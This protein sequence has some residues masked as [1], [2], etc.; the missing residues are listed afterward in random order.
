MKVGK[1]VFLSL[2][3][4][5]INL[6]VVQ[7]YSQT[8]FYDETKVREIRITFD[9]P[10][11]SQILDSLFVNFGEDGRLK[12]EVEIDGKTLNNIGVRYKGYS[13]WEE[14]QVKS[15]FN[16]D[17]EYNLNEQNYQ[18]YTKLKL[19]NVIH[20][21]SFV[22]EVLSY[23]IARKYMPAP[24]ANFANVY[25]NDTLIGLYTNVE[26]VDKYFAEDRY[27]TRN[28]SF[29]KGAPESLEYPFGQNANLA[30][31]HGTDTSDYKPFYKKESDNDEAWPDLLEFIEILNNDTANLDT[32]LNIDRTIWMHAINYSIVNLDSYIGYSQNYYLYRDNNGQFNPI[33]WDMN[34]SFGSFRETDGTT[35][36]LSIAKAK[37]LNPLKM[38]SSST[39]SPRPLIKN[40]LLNSTYKRMFLAHMR[41]IIDENFRNNLYYQRAQELQALINDH[42]LADS[43]KFY[44]YDDFINNIDTTTG[45]SSD[46][47]PGIKDLMEARTAYL[48][49]FPG[50]KGAPIITDISHYPEYPDRE[51][52]TWIRAKISGA[53]E[54]FLAYRFKSDGKFENLPMYDDGLHSDGNAGDSIFGAGFLLSGNTIQYYF[55]AQN[56]SAGAFSPERAAFEFYSIQPKISPGDIVINEFMADNNNTVADLDGRYDSWIELYNNT[57]ESINLNTVCL[58]DDSGLKCKWTFPDTAINGNDFII[59]WT[60]AD[61]MQSGLHANFK[62]NPEGSCLFL[63]EGNYSFD[64]IKYGSQVSDKT[65]GRY[66]NG[67]GDFVSMH[68]T[69]SK[70][71]SVSIMQNDFNLYP[72]PA[73]TSLWIEIEN[74]ENPISVKIYNSLS[75]K[76]L[77]FELKNEAD[78]R[79]ILHNIDISTLRNDYYLLE[80]YQDNKFYSKKFIKCK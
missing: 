72:N 68:P 71:N 36:N 64:S 25:V 32:I 62:L 3:A 79:S 73:S 28:N 43:N 13:S 17:L 44:S 50:F 24:K 16:I 30:Y 55:Y 4:L 14:G 21:P 9:E 54:V 67:Y 2:F 45:P 5:F 8:D 57:S 7:V 37:Q 49:T 58:S 65:T 39:Y 22:R 11:W 31:T 76:V 61:E 15:P 66:P 75:M 19:S 74:S 38:I 53:N 63:T 70:Y 46:Q 60:D 48:D 6:L 35:L 18:G 42:V 20:D 34:M 23:E 40:L 56:D 29:F 51:N 41:T 1:K 12:G 47:Y 78:T 27:H 77:E 10:N 80:L 69:Y 52:T 33:L 26:A 59:I